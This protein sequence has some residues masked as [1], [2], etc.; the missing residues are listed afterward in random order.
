MSLKQKRRALAV[1]LASFILVPLAYSDENP[2]EV[3]LRANVLLGDGVPANDV[4]G[5]GVIGRYRLKDGWFI[6]AAFDLYEYDRN[7]ASVT[8]FYLF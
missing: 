8:A 3:G 5:L 1:C 2:Y 7:V 4:L 6:G